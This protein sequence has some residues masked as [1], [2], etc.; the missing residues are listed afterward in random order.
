MTQPRDRWNSAHGVCRPRGPG[1]RPACLAV[2]QRN[3]RR[4]HSWSGRA[5][6]EPGRSPRARQVDA[7]PSR[8]PRAMA[9]LARGERAMVCG[10]WR[11]PGRRAYFVPLSDLVPEHWIKVAAEGVSAG[12]RSRGP[13][14]QR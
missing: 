5:F 13:A 9:L 11:R 6:G 8:P 10:R 14:C 3:G 12:G 2:T 1:L 4:I 7:L